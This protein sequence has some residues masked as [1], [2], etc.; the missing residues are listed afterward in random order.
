MAG[1]GP[2]IVR[3]ASGRGDALPDDLHPVL[4]RVYAARGLRGPEELSL[5]LDRLLAPEAVY[6]MEAGAELLAGAVQSGARIL[7]VGDFD[8]DGATS[9]AVGVL[10]LRALG[11]ETVHYLVPN[12]FEYGYGLS[13]E[14]VTVAAD[15]RPDL[16]VTVDNGTAS[17]A[18]VL[19]AQRRGIRVLVTD[20][21]L[22]APEL[23]PA[24]AIVNPNLVEGSAA[25]NLAGVGVIFYVLL[26]VRARLRAAGWF[27]RRGIEPPKLAALLDLVALG[28]V[29]DLVPL[30]Y[31]NRILVAQ[32]LARIRAG[33]CRPGLAALLDIAGRRRRAAVAADL[34]FAAAPRLNAA[35]R[36]E[37]MALGIE[38]LLA[39]DTDAA[40]AM[41][42]RLDAFNRERRAIEH[43]MHAQALETLESLPREGPEEEGLPAG[44][45]LFDPRWHQGVIGILAARIRERFHRPVIALAPAGDLLKGSAR[46][47]PGLHI[48]DTL[49]AVA[50][51]NP[52]IIERFGGHAMA[53]GLTLAPDRLAALQAAFAAEVDRR[54]APEDRGGTLLTDG[55]LA[56][57]E[58][59]LGTAQALREAGPWGQGFP[60]PRFD[61]E[62]E[63]LD[64]RVVGEAHLKLTVR[65]LDGARCVDAIAFRTPAPE[66]ALC[67]V[68]LAYR[69]DVN[70]YRGSRSAQLLV[71]RIEAL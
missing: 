22:P 26:A 51:R 7:L 18:G 29:A 50:A 70:E 64:Q 46:S 12:R 1:A 43:E 44:L 57:A 13:P 20:H 28:T 71:E 6:G 66:R 25:R 23:P 60:E 5:S 27:R 62:F 21:H 4:R 42:A 30:D 58:L 24:D 55:A 69:L 59:D 61:G 37:D 68:R 56:A 8:A 31:N 63:V 40:Q 33:R 41:A 67:R 52:G 32:G 54:L 3:R 45:C 34:A 17:R 19:E 2:R 11:A 35:G 9:C 47:V 14:L 53:A 49:E 48:R 65:P 16:L 38:C 39:A 36:L 15:W 10:G